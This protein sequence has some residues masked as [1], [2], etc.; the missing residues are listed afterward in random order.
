MAGP[1]LAVISEGLWRRR[2]G[3]AASAIGRDVQIDGELYTVVGVAPAQLRGGVALRRLDPARPGGRSR[4]PR[5]QLSAVARPAARGHDA[6]RRRAGRWASSRRRCRAITATTTTP[7]RCARCTTW[8]PKAQAEGYGCCS[9]PT[10]LLLLISCTNVANLLLA[11]SVA[12]ER[13]LAVRASLGAGRRQ[14]VSQVLG[15][16]VALG[17]VGSVAGAALAWA[18]LRTFVGM[19]PPNFPRLAAITLDLRVLALTAFDRRH[20]RR[21]RR[22]A[23]GRAPVPVGSQCGLARRRHARRHR[24]SRPIGGPGAGRLRDRP[25]AGAADDGWRDGEE[26]AAAAGR[27]PG[28]HARAG[29]HL[30]GEP[31]AVRRRGGRGHRALPDGVPAPRSRRSPASR[32]RPPS[33][34]CRWA[35]TGSNG[36]VRRPDQVGEREGVPVTEVRVVMDGY[37]DAMGVRLLA[38]RAIDERDRKDA[39]ARGRRQPHA[40]RRGC[41]P[42]SRRPR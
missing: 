38:G 20:R 6:R 10:V 37:T 9:A 11:R 26:P 2:F 8:S 36:I 32:G 17:L 33:T 19:A 41:G 28:P 12:R 25:R 42:R 4:E 7:S 39:T 15:E 35:A 16:T 5:H 27:G 3:G 22:P 13:D 34:C 14:L 21:H 23:S 1:A 24:Q 30:C 18:L 40:W 31:A 29:A